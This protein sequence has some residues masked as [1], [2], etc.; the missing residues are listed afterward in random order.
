MSNGNKEHHDLNDV[1]HR[2]DNL[3]RQLGRLQDLATR[4]LAEQVSQTAYLK[5]I[6]E[7]LTPVSTI[8]AT[9]GKLTFHPPTQRKRAMAD[10]FNPQTSVIGSAAFTKPDPNDPS[11]VV[12]GQVE[13][14]PVWA[15]DGN[16]ILIVSDD[17]F[18]ATIDGSANVSNAVSNIT[19]TGDGDLG[20]GIVPVVLTG[21][22][23]W[24][25]T[26]DIE[27]TGGTLTLTAAPAP[28]SARRR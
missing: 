28:A 10:I 1:C 19:V 5:S 22:I 2:L 17:G 11:A 13:G 15:V 23:S 20:K 8:G 18:T 16:A 3:C 27:A 21:S 9:G 25:Q 6:S 12:P 7:Q 24:E 26:A 4:S 14:V